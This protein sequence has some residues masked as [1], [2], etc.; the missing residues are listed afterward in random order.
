[1]NEKA[2]YPNKNKINK[3]IDLFLAFR[4][5]AKNKYLKQILSQSKMIFVNDTHSLSPT[6]K[7]WPT[8]SLHSFAN[9]NVTSNKMAH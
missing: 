7:L 3:K 5:K 6:K 4:R 2:N 1:M 9:A 8:Y